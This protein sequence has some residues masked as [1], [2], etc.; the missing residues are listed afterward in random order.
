[1]KE[2]SITVLITIKNNASTVKEC[3]NSLLK[4]NYYNYEILVV[5]AFS[6]DGTYEIL[7]SFGSKI[8]LF[9]V[10]GWT[11][12]AYN[13]AIKRIKSDFVAFTDGDCVI[14]RNWLR[15][16]MKGFSS[17]DILAVAGYCGTPR[18]ARGLQRIIGVELEDRFKHFPKYIQRAPTMNICVR[19]KTLRKLKF[20]ESLQVAFETDLG[21]RINRY[22]RILFQE[23]AI[24]YHYH[25]SSWK[26]FFRQQYTYAKFLPYLYFTKHLKNIRG[27]AISKTR[28]L[29]QI[30]FIYMAALGMMLSAVFPLFTYFSGIMLAS[31]LIAYMFDIKRLSRSSN[32]TAY[33]LALFI[34]RNVAWSIGVFVGVIRLVKLRIFS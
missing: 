16:L 29:L 8:K 2:P 3:I 14:D 20:D 17:E 31:L 18:S 1:M 22:G 32:D 26:G 7:K 23:S 25:R 33:F 34:V 21:Y 4:Q 27:D 6:T 10:K 5:D 30:I 15:E 9:Q 28:M 11:P 13:W 19:T 24:I 12:V